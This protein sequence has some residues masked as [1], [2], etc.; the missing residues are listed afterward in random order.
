MT[1]VVRWNQ[2]AAG[3]SV[4]LLQ[5]GTTLADPWSAS[6]APINNNPVQDI[7]DYT[8]K[9]AVVPVDSARKFV[10]VKASE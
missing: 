3:T 2:R 5:E 10:R 4:Y 8:R 1:L 9:E 7:P 6:T